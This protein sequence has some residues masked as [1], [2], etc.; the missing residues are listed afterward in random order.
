M[1]ID[2]SKLTQFE[3]DLEEKSQGTSL[4]FNASKIPGSL[5]CRIL[6]P[7]PNMDGMYAFEVVF[8]W[9]GKVKVLS[10]E[11]FGE[12]DW[13]QKMLDEAKAVKDP[14]LD[15]LLN[16]KNDF[17]QP[18]IR[19]QT[20]YWIPFIIFDW[21]L[22]GDNITGIWKDENTADVS[23][24][25]NF[26]RDKEGKILTTKIQLT[27]AINRE[28]TTRGGSLMFDKDKGFNLILGK[29][30]EKRETQYTASKADYLPMPAKYYGEGTPDV[31]NICKAGIFT[32]EYIDNIVGQYL[33]GDVPI[34]KS[35]TCYRYPEIRAAM[36]KDVPADDAPTKPKRPERAAIGEK[37]AETTVSEADRV[38]TPVEEKTPTGRT[39]PSTTARAATKEDVKATTK[40]STPARN[41]TDDLKDV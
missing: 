28:A 38:E 4:F 25:D 14:E 21:E 15:K 17:G 31:V 33:Y 7:L 37:P 30:G 26:I 22:D 8:W 36:K 3:A 32:D 18:K 16:A 34:E 10:A 12:V 39:A 27:K 23:L 24:I 5:D 35:D 29:T 40:R 20:E 19:K 2:Q 1:P 11:I 9:V 13:V 6:D 41:V